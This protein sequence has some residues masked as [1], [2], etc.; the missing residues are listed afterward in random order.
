VS[1]KMEVWIHKLRAMAENS[2]YCVVCGVGLGPRK[3][4]RNSAHLCPEH[5]ETHTIQVFWENHPP[6]PGAFTEYNI[7]RPWSW[8]GPDSGE[9]T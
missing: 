2:K 1:G 3:I 9:L 6:P 8:Q 7:P 4:D 5:Y